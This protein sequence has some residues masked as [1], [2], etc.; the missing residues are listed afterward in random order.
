MRL[1]AFPFSPLSSHS[2]LTL[3]RYRL[4]CVSTIFT[5]FR[6]AAAEN[7]DE[8]LWQI[9]ADINKEFRPILKRLKNGPHVVERR[10]VET[11][12]NNFLRVALQFYKGYV[13]RLSARYDIPELSRV[14]QGMDAEQMPGIDRISPVPADLSAL[15]LKSCHI[16]MIHLGDL[17]RYKLQARNKKTGFD[18]ALACYSLAHDLIPESGFAFHQM[19][20]INLEEGNFLEVVYLFY[21]AW[22]VKDPHP[23]AKQNLENT[24]KT[25]QSSSGTPRG[26]PSATGSSDA[27]IMWFLRLHAVFY[28]GAPMAQQ[29][30]ELDTEVMHRLSLAVKDHTCAPTLFKMSLVNMAAFCIAVENYKGMECSR[31]RERFIRLKS[32]FLVEK[33]SSQ[34]N[35]ESASRFC[36]FVL[37]FNIRF[38]CKLC[39]ALETELKDSY[40]RRQEDHGDESGDESV[41]Q[42]PSPSVEAFLPILR[43]YS[44]WLAAHRQHIFS[45]AEALGD[46]L[47]PMLRSFASVFTLLTA[48]AYSHDDLR[49]CPYLL[50]EDLDIRGLRSFDEDQAFPVSIRTHCTED[51]KLKP[52]LQQ[53][54]D[55]LPPEG[56]Y[57]ARIL[58]ALRCVYQLADDKD[59]PLGARVVDNWLVFE[60]QP[61]GV[62]RP[63]QEVNRGPTVVGNGPG[64]DA[65]IANHAKPTEPPQQSS[66]NVDQPN[67]IPQVV[68]GS[69]PGDRTNRQTANQLDD[70]ENTVV[71]MVSS[72]LEDP[73]SEPGHNASSIEPSYG[74]HSSTAN[75]LAR[76]ML[77]NFQPANEAVLQRD[78]STEAGIFGPQTWDWKFPYT[79]TPPRP[80]ESNPKRTNGVSYSRHGSNRSSMTSLP[81]P[82]SLDDPFSSPNPGGRFATQ[83]RKAS[84]I[85]N[86]AAA[87]PPASD[88]A[89]RNQLLQAF[90][91]KHEAQ[92]SPSL[93]WAP[94]NQWGGES[95]NPS[96][97]AWSSWGPNNQP[98]PVHLPS[99]SNASAF[100]HMS[101]LYQ[102]TPATRP[103]SGATGYGHYDINQPTRAGTQGNVPVP[104]NRHF[105]MDETASNYDAAVF[106]AAWQGNA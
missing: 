71:D 28:K 65:G 18:T 40:R 86:F 44:M 66:V 49:S 30:S 91:N 3:Y 4:G 79:P 76:E 37:N 38:I 13:Q 26:R 61:L 57:A 103:I 51:G 46:V 100:T 90:T 12:Y 106:Q 35:A 45:A 97:Q 78:Q 56:E 80:Q 87:R 52:H 10:K 104:H 101:S 43:V 15:V 84:N 36:H 64:A 53:Q 77:A 9:H 99:S 50:P 75:E 72:F 11:K 54:T 25:V 47:Q 68:P 55:R 8:M 88:D 92:R 19:G 94:P 20:I 42:S 2:R 82:D 29:H 83:A 34:D 22:A 41:K 59:V 85:P 105:Q 6:Y 74:I 60:Y 98:Q 93:N 5:D 62:P 69:R 32:N 58:D 67:A 63:E 39:E 81:I 21:R 73:V 70:T 17:S 7:V 14:A 24:F 16:T 102:G 95:G 33:L 27:F 48:E 89:H 23:N 1:T 96:A 31:A